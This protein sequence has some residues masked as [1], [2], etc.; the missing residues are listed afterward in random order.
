MQIQNI[1]TYSLIVISNSNLMI[2]LHINIY[3]HISITKYSEKQR[4]VKGRPKTRSQNPMQNVSWET[5]IVRYEHSH[6][7]WSDWCDMMKLRI[8]NGASH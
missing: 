7:I 5:K 4:D 3:K 8:K 6:F 1:I 2:L